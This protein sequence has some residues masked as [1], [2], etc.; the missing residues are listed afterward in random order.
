V[1]LATLAGLAGVGA[2]GWLLT[3]RGGF[4]RI[5]TP[6][7]P[8]EPK[9][10]PAV[11]AVIPAR[12]EAEG[13]GGT[14]TSLLSQDYPG[15]LSVVVV[16]DHSSDGTADIA[17]AAA[18]AIGAADRLT[19]VAAPDLPPGWA[20][21]MW[22]QNHGIAT[23]RVRHPDL[24]L[25]LLTDADIDH[26]PRQLRDQVARL[27]CHR[28]DMASLMV[29]LPTDGVWEQA[30]IPAFVFFFR[31]LY[32]FAWVSDP[33]HS[34]AAAAGGYVLIRPEALD[35]IGGVAAIHNAL[36]DDCS[37]AAAVKR[38]GWRIR[39]D[40]SHDTVSSRRYLGPAGLWK[41]ISRSA[42]TQLNHSPLLLAGTVAAMLLVFV[43]PPLLALLGSGTAAL[44]GLIAWA[45]MSFAYAPMVR[46][47]R[48][49]PAWSVALP[50]VA[51]FYLGATLDSAVQY[52]LGRGGAWKGRVQDH[53]GGAK[54]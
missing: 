39:L 36:I 42:Y 16:D 48:V 43:A 38:A 15:A 18:A 22:A 41:M 1:S 47:Y 35:D 54:S 5:E 40:L 24:D 4:W 49:A 33:A 21:K 32:P 20:G 52:W 29:R 27:L 34:T 14:V 6:P 45:A 10:W 3:L 25:L 9:D 19:V 44:C 12:D 26:A 37:L 53:R 7:S 13:I 2:W 17:R 28:L 23:A 8:S 46:A 50:L 11:V 30:V 51:L 31:M